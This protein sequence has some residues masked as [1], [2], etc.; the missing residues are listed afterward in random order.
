M[1]KPTLSGLVLDLKLREFG[2]D[3]DIICL[4]AIDQQLVTEMQETIR[5]LLD[6]R[7][8]IGGVIRGLLN[9]IKA[10]DR[11]RY[12]MGAGTQTFADLT[13]SYALAST[14]DVDAI[15]ETVIPGSAAFY[16]A[17][18]RGPGTEP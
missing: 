6:Q 14:L 12:L 8:R 16:R 10:D 4:H 18:E 11:Y 7:E 5:D 3:A 17:T 2:G 9:K 1:S 13:Q 15:R